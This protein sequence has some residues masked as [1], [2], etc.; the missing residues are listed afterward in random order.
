MSFLLQ[1]KEAGAKHQYTGSQLGLERLAAQKRK[2]KELAGG[3]NPPKRAKTTV[4]GAWAE[5]ETGEEG[6]MD[7]MG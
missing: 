4:V 7:K 6:E 1:D 5:E 3:G 2:E